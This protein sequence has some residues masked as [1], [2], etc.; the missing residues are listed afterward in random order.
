MATPWSAPGLRKT[1]TLTRCASLLPSMRTCELCAWAERTL[2]H[3]GASPP[4]APRPPDDAPTY[5]FR[6]HD[7]D[8]KCEIHGALLTLRHRAPAMLLTYMATCCFARSAVRARN[9]R[10]LRA[11]QGD[12]S[13]RGAVHSSIQARCSALCCH[14]AWPASGRVGSAAVQPGAAPPCGLLRA[15]AQAR[16]PACQRRGCG[17]AAVLVCGT[18]A[19]TAPSAASS[20][21]WQCRAGPPAGIPPGRCRRQQRGRDAA[22]CDCSRRDACFWDSSECCVVGNGCS[23]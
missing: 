8:R 15:H 1:Q 19:S 11:V 13:R 4:V 3:G 12:V 22:R 16:L 18:T 7:S 14:C 2:R 10:A 9:A 21:Q 23:G 6:T 5:R 17:T 20:R